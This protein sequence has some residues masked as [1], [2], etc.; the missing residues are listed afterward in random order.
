MT[1][2]LSI[3]AL[4]CAAGLAHAETPAITRA[5]VTRL[6]DTVAQSKC[7]FNR[8][9]TWYDA[10]SA[11]KHLRDKFDYLDKRNMLVNTESFIE[12]G[13]ARSSSSGK[14]YKIF[15]PGGTAVPSAAWL[16]TELDKLRGPK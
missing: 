10:N 12:K 13:A 4:L 3:A 15:C 14:E 8:N 7:T 11:S 2:R 1:R 9:G 16:T 5:E 6:L